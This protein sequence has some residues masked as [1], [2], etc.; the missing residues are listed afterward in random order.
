MKQM[1][2]A[3]TLLTGLGACG[4]APQAE[5][6]QVVGQPAADFKLA[7]ANGRTVS[8]SDYRGKTV[9][10]EWHNPGCPSVQKH[11]G[12]GNMQ[13]TQ[14]AAAK[15]DVV[16]LTVNSGAP[17]K[18]GHMTAAEARAHL[19]EAGARPAAYLL[20]SNGTVGRAYG[21]KT[22]PQ[23]FIADGAGKLVYAGGIDDKPTTSSDDIAGARNHVLAALSELKAGKPVSVPTSR[24]YGC[25]VK[26]ADS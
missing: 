20:D 12:S 24:P 5:A 18:Q 14:A 15:D 2:V 22:T 6:P 21:A 13:R 25:S 11:Y 17:G 19:A 4:G 8:L 1:L 16:W 10:L 7:D 26:Y 23:I 9:V 3:F